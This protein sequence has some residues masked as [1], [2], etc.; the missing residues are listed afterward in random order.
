MLTFGNDK[1]W[2]KTSIDSYI[3]STLGD[4]VGECEWNVYFIGMLFSFQGIK[5]MQGLSL[6][7]VVLEATSH[8]TKG[9]PH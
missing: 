6:L 5:F 2:S 3:E 7:L 1:L 4:F 8:G 9:M